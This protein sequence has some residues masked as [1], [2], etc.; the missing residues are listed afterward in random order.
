MNALL[1]LLVACAAVVFGYGWY[2]RRI[3]RQVI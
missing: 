1:V 2:A 3:D